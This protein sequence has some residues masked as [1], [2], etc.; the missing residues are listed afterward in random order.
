MGKEKELYIFFLIN[1]Q[2]QW[3][4]FLEFAQ[5]FNDYGIKLV[6]VTHEE[7]PGM[8]FTQKRYLISVT[9]NV[10]SA[11]NFKRM[12]K[13]FIDFCLKNRKAFIFDIS[14][15]SLFEKP[16]DLVRIDVYKKY[17][18]PMKMS[19]LIESIVEEFVDRSQDKLTWPG[20]RR[21]KLPA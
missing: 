7:L 17:Q 21:A 9:N 10:E 20:G 8:D 2:G 18:L 13:R 12:R 14:S 11:K 1:S 6:P 16:H 19:E 3:P 15:F 5:A 4:L